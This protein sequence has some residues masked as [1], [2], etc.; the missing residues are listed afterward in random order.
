MSNSSN[1]TAT[2]LSLTARAF[3]AWPKVLPNATYKAH[4]QGTTGPF[5]P[6]MCDPPGLPRV[7]QYA[8][9]IPSFSSAT[10]TV[11][12]PPGFQRPGL[13]RMDPCGGGLAD[14]ARWSPSK[15]PGFPG[16]WSRASRAPGRPEPRAWQLAHERRREEERRAS[17]SSGLGARPR[18]PRRL[19]REVRS[20]AAPPSLRPARPARTHLGSAAGTRRCCRCC[21]CCRSS[22]PARRVR[23]PAAA[24]THARPPRTSSRR[25]RARSRSPQPSAVLAAAVGHRPAGAATCDAVSGLGCCKTPSSWARAVLHRLPDRFSQRAGFHPGAHWERRRPEQGGSPCILRRRVSLQ[26]CRQ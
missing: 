4:T 3:P 8:D 16:P 14:H 20:A 23:L 13:G 11:R 18:V 22:F 26:V 9:T 6:G 24:R 10:V 1:T 12:P 2:S 19:S 21:R 17:R 7:H 5:L 25:E 15:C